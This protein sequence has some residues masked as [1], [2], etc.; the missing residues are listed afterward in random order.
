MEIS[1]W[2]KFLFSC[3]AVVQ[4]SLGLHRSRDP[5]H[6][7][8]FEFSW[9]ICESGPGILR[10][11]KC[12]KASKKPKVLAQTP[13][14]R[15]PHLEGDQTLFYVLWHAIRPILPFP[16]NIPLPVNNGCFCTIS[17]LLVFWFA[18]ALSVFQSPPTPDNKPLIVSQ[19]RYTMWSPAA[20]W[21]AVQNPGEHHCLVIRSL[22]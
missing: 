18:V 21:E 4:F 11:L 5:V 6:L 19:M 10:N 14:L 9:S 1:F 16:L 17:I 20:W 7:T 15:P 3:T 2:T 8:G 12:T 13:Y 22:S